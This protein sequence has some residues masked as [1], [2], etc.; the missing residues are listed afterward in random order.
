MRAA[1]A[2][3]LHSLDLC[4]SWVQIAGICCTP[5][6]FDEQQLQAGDAFHDSTESLFLKYCSSLSG[7]E[8]HTVERSS[9]R[10]PLPTCSAHCSGDGLTGERRLPV[11]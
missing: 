11:G 2:L 10:T 7:G 5:T 1:A 9:T 4:S 8:W 6:R 3:V